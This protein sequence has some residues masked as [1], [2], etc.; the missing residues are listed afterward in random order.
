M[1]WTESQSYSDRIRR[2]IRLLWVLLAAM[3][4]YMVIV[5]ELGLGDTRV[6][7]PFAKSAGSIMCFG[8]LGW[9]IWRIR[10]NRQLLQNPWLLHQQSTEEADE[11]NRYLH[12]K[13][14][15]IVW[16]LLFVCLFVVTMTA[17]LVN[18]P[19]FYTCFSLFVI[20]VAL[21]ALAYLYYSTTA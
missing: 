17:S 10:C 8:T 2:R 1:K 16:D 9:I 19:A 20:A 18:M 12:D 6:I 4:G 15:G 11:R 3:L 21:K 5:G 7:T 14:G 13:S